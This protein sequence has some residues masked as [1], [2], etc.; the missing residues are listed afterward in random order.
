M[1]EEFKRWVVGKSGP[2]LLV[3][4]LGEKLLWVF[5]NLSLASPAAYSHGNCRSCVRI[6][7]TATKRAL[8]ISGLGD[9]G[10]KSGRNLTLI[11][12]E[13]DA[14]NT[15]ASNLCASK[16]VRFL[17]ITPYSRE[18]AKD[19]S[20]ITEDGLHYSGKSNKHYAQVVFESL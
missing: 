19:P 7:I 18:I 17:D 13:I 9:F 10:K 4:D 15:F 5:R 14:Y 6:I 3:C 8:A 11:S 1:V 2:F 20:F 16:N 12:K